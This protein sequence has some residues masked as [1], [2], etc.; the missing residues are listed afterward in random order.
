MGFGT[1]ILAQVQEYPN[2][3]VKKHQPG[4]AT[5]STLL[6]VSNVF[7]VSWAKALPLILG[8]GPFLWP[9]RNAGT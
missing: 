5:A 9:H 4:A 7:M 8:T 3:S 2:P 6:L 1:E